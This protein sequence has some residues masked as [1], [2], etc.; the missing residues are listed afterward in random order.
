M[1]PVTAAIEHNHENVC[2]TLKKERDVNDTA[3]SERG[4][5]VCMGVTFAKYTCVKM[6]ATLH[7]IFNNIKLLFLKQKIQ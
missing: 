7:T 2:M 3:W 6:D 1:G 5:E 4:K